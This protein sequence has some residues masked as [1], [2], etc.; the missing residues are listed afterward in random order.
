MNALWLRIRPYLS[1][2]VRY[3]HISFLEAKSDYEGTTLGIMWIPVGT[4]SFSLLIG[5]VLHANGTMNPID[6]FLYVLSGYIAWNFIADTISRSTR[7]IQGKFDFAVHNNLTLAGLFGKLLADR[8]FEFL[9]E[10][11]TLFIAVLLLAPWLYGPQ[12]LLLLVLFPMLALVSL[13]LSYLVNLMT[14]FFPDLGNLVSQGVRLMFFATP[15]FWKIE[16]ASD[17]RILLETLNP[18]AYFLMMMRQCFG[19]EPVES[20]VWLIGALITLIVA[21]G[22]WYA[23]YRSNSF[24]KNL[25]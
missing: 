7:I 6:F 5:F 25:R 12:I 2:F 18:A 20:H 15:I 23:Y 4:L 10:L 9:L 19:I 1:T 3:M 16:D 22:G 24:V 13:G 14:L 8:G 11:A 21:V 17:S